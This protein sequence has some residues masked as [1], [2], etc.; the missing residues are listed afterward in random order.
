MK[1]F[2]VSWRGTI[3]FLSGMLLAGSAF[4][5][6]IHTVRPGESLSRIAQRYRVEWKKI[7]EANGLEGS[8]LQA[9]QKLKIPVS[10][11]NLKGRT[12]EEKAQP[13]RLSES[14]PTGDLDADTYVV[15]PG[16]TL[17][18]IARK[19]GLR[20]DELKEINGLRGDRLKVGQILFLRLMEEGDEEIE[21]ETTEASSRGE[22]AGTDLP[23]PPEGPS[24][25]F[26]SEKEQQLL[27][28]I[29]QSFLGA[30]YKKG[31][32]S[33]QGMDCSAF[34]Q[35]V[36]WIFGVELPRTAREQFQAGV[37]VAR[38]ALQVG[39]LLFF[40][41]SRAR[42][43]THVAIYLG[44]DQF[45]HTSLSKRQV[46]IDSL[47]S[48]YFRSRFIGARRITGQN[49]STIFGNLVYNNEF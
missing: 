2:P 47:E 18:R 37:R 30:R 28:R 32:T 48:K 21:G 39:D 35:K 4:G 34:V 45:I 49:H 17:S 12:V 8:I 20:V 29:A 1:S 6:V 19:F 24:G 44:N 33:I 25:L 31:G 38:E 13:K 14:D 11:P 42:F 10:S 3:L 27:V 16:D 22:G 36:F 9:G 7:H 26:A 41:R 40:K 46:K 5:E 15:K 43:P 23:H